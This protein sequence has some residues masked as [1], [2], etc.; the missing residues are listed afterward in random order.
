MKVLERR[1]AALSLGEV[2]REGLKRRLKETVAGEVRFDTASRALYANGGGS[3]YRLPPIGVVLPRT[4]EDIVATHEACREFGAPVLPRG[5][6][7]SLAGQTCNVAVVVD[8][9]KY[10]NRVL[11]IDPDAR[12]ARVQPGLVLDD[13]RRAAE[14]HGLT[15]GPD[16]STHAYCTLGGMLGNNSCGVHSVMSQLFGPGPTTADNVHELE[17]LTYRGERLRVGKGD[18]GLPTE[19]AAGLHD[20]ADRYGGLIRERYP[21]IPR[22]VSG[23]NLDRLLPERDFDVAGAL[24]GTEGTC[25][26]ILE[27]TVHLLESPPAR[28]LLVVGYHDAADAA[29]HVP[30]I[31]EHGPIGLEGIDDVL[32][33]DMTLVGIHDED[34]SLM[35]EGRGWLLVEFGG[36][37][38]E[39]ADDK[40]RRLMKRLRKDAVDMKLYDDRAQE[41]HVW[42]VRE[43]GLGATAFVPG[44]EDAWEGWED[45][46]VPP[47]RVGEY[48]RALRE[49]AGRYGYESALYG[50][51]GQGCIHARWNFDLR[52]TQGIA[53]WR[54]FLE[55]ASDLVLSL[56]GSLSGEHGDGQARAELLPKMFG[57]ELVGAMREFKELWD[58][59]WKMN[60]GKVVAPYRI[61]ENL[62]LGTDY[63]PPRPDVKFA[64]AEDGGDFA[65]AALR[66]VGIGKCRTPAGVDV[67]CPSYIVTRE[68]MHSTRGRARL[69]FEML[70]GEIVTD[71]WRSQEV[72]DALD[73][74][75]A[76]KGCT[77]DCPTSVDMPTYKA[78]FLHHHWRGRLRPRS[79]YA[80][81]L[82][83]RWSRLAALLPEAV[84]LL[85]HAPGLA[86]LAKLATGMT[87]EREIPRFAS[88]TFQQWHERRGGTRHPGGTR[89]LLWPDT[90][91][92]HFH[93]EVGVAAVEA[94]E[95]A[96]VEVVV[97]QGHVCCGR[98]LYDYG[99]LD[100]ARNYLTRTLDRFRD[101]LRAGTPFLVL[102]PSCAATF[103]DE[104]G[105][106]LPHDDD[107]IR[108]KKQTFH[109]AELVRELGLEPS[110]IAGKA[111]LWGHC[112]HKA[113]GGIEP[114]QELLERLG[115][116]VEKVTGG[117]CGLAGSWGFETG[118]YELSMAC[119]DHALLPA[120]RTA[121]PETLVVA[122]GFS[123]RT[124]VEHG[125]GRRA[126][127]LAEVLA[128]ARTG[129]LPEPPRAPASLRALRVAAPAVLAAATGVAALQRRK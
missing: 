35:P 81:G 99:F 90:F 76:C 89:V 41:Q 34:L 88:L 67:M 32:V 44:K 36:E 61:D 71:G 94:L 1:T 107:A 30:E 13:L 18:G 19:L 114:E 33:E 82:I 105:K 72:F 23:Y 43:A 121:A 116:E 57:E 73:V 20:L 65:H 101:E 15:F 74:C 128:L 9:S 85:A 40:A 16:P 111:L 11:E 113:T 64:Y 6:G 78:E 49:L 59:D 87:R 39:E 118:H 60:P 21:Q 3:N 120:V 86:R 56:G 123:C 4:V 58:P 68:E 42:G 12:V 31:L 37:T 80:F 100:L 55:E 54:R 10:L 96:G 83:D 50:H 38:K 115:L 129:R 103:K 106:L 45:S 97:P 70:N 122:D 28:S 7:T 66:C 110:P 69:L 8:C 29:D 91:T 126:L 84:N 112:H 63:N 117:C 14:E 26:S 22:R 104:L 17:V 102:E 124:Q 5:G 46:A 51:Y 95:A 27:A 98:P 2:D 75:L 125:A 93:P 77:H 79:A 108:L 53:T 25:V 48:I 119:G 92:N 127:H 109:L 47:E 62:R 24:V 52:T